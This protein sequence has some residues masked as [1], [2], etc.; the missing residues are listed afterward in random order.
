[1][2]YVDSGVQ[3]TV[4]NYLPSRESNVTRVELMSESTFKKTDVF[5]FEITPLEN[6]KRIIFPFTY[7]KGETYIL[8]LYS[9]LEMVFYSKLM[10]NG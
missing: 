6:W 1:M 9:E 3:M 7:K 2:I 8:K 10:V 4:V 5:E